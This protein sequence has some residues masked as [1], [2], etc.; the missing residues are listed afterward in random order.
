MPVL[1]LGGIGTLAVWGTLLSM[2]P[3]LVVRLA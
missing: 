3:T 1:I 2:T